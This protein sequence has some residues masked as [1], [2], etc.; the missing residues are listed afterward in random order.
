MPFPCIG[1]FRFLELERTISDPNYQFVLARLRRQASTDTL[2][3]VGCFVGQALRALAFDG[4]DPKRLYGTDLEQAY[5]DLGYELFRDRDKIEPSHLIAGDMLQEPRDTRL[6]AFVGRMTYIH[7]SSFFH[8]FSWPLQVRAAK[9]CIEFLQPDSK[10]AMIFGGMVGRD[11]AGELPGPGGSKLFMH[12]AQSW[13]KLWDEVGETTGTTWATDYQ[14]VEDAAFEKDNPQYAKVG[15]R[16]V[17]F[18][19]RR[20]TQV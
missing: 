6:D 1:Q 9:R 2:L 16:R 10:D 5:L 14:F 12:N 18:A 4:V 17:R 19:V 13:E 7:A 15:V 8:L 20:T 3:D 11:N